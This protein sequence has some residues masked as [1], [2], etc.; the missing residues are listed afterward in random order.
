MRWYVLDTSAGLTFLKEEPGVTLLDELFRDEQ[1]QFIIS[2]LIPFEI[3]YTTLRKHSRHTADLFLRTT[4][5]FGFEI[6]YAN[7]MDEIIAAGLLKGKFRLSAVDA[8]IAA[9]AV[10]RQ[11]ILV[12]R[13]P[14]FE[15]LKDY[16]NLLSLPYS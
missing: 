5:Q 4:L 3:F 10:R 8:W 6:D 16:L 1:N 12:H 9:P 11:A 14:E 7:S 13:D 2:F 15:S